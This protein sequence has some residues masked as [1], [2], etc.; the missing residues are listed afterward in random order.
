M[1][2]VKLYT[3]NGE[4]VAE[5]IIEINQPDIIYFKDRLFTYSPKHAQYREAFLVAAASEED[6]FFCHVPSIGAKDRCLKC[7]TPID[8]SSGK[9]YCEKHAIGVCGE[10]QNVDCVHCGFNHDSP[11]NLQKK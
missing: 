1:G 4:L 7:T 2:E 10:H 5:A 11:D 8:S 3:K 9:R 6:K